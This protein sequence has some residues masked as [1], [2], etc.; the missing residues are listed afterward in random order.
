MLKENLCTLIDILIGVQR[1]QGLQSKH[2][3]F[4]LV[5][6]LCCRKQLKFYKRNTLFLSQ[7]IVII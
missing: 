3:I 1:F 5:N 6:I 2:I 4:S 7:N